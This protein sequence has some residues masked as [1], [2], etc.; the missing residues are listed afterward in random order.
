M[1]VLFIIAVPIAA[2]SLWLYLKSSP[3]DTTL[4][5]RAGFEI[6]VLFLEL[7]GCFAVSYYSY[8]TVGHGTDSAW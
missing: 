6:L 8:S 3:V 4:K 1:I 7:A 2:I 5:S